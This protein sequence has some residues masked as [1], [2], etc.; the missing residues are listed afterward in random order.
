MSF[1]LNFGKPLEMHNW[2]WLVR[3]KNNDE[4]DMQEAVLKAKKSDVIVV[5]AGIEEGEFQDRSRLTLPGKQEE[6]ILQ[7]A[8]TGKPIVVVLVG[9][10]AIVM[11]HWLNESGWGCYVV[12]CRMSSRVMLLRTY[13]LEKLI[14]VESCRLHFR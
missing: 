2:P 4:S 8:K 7:L 5:V 14:Q 12:V 1:E 3:R 11:E 9:G 6:L 10:S 13:C